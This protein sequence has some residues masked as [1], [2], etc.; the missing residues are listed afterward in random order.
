MKF[1]YT[2]KNVAVTD[3]MK[4]NAEQKISRIRRLVSESAE[5]F[6]TFS[7][8]RHQCKVEVSV[9]L[10]KR[11]LRAE[12]TAGDFP[13]CLDS[14]ADVLEKQVVRYKGRLRERN[15]RNAA[16]PEELSFIADTPASEEPDGPV[17][18][19]T[20]RFALKPMDAL[21]AVLTMDL[22]GHAFFVFRDDK[23]DEINVVYKRKD[24]EYGLI[25]HD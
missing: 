12:V 1:I 6:V 17:I 2:G 13:A 18:H 20:K 8:I 15:R 14:V 19:R 23:T 9:P 3:D 10:H 25:E 5:V 11:L 21:E 24:G 4:Q 16:T 7:Q 22:L